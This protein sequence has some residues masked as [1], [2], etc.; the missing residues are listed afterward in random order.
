M[1]IKSKFFLCCFSCLSLLFT[2]N[3][4][5]LNSNNSSKS[6]GD[7]GS[8]STFVDDEFYI[9]DV[10][11]LTDPIKTS[12]AVGE[13]VDLTGMTFQVTW[14]DGY[15]ENVDHTYAI[16][17]PA[18]VK[19]DTTKIIVHYDKFQ[20]ELPVSAVQIA[21]IKIT[22]QPARTVYV[23]NEY[24]NPSGLG[25]SSYLSNGDVYKEILDFDYY[26][27][28]PLTKDDTKITITSSDNYEVELPIQVCDGYVSEAED[29]TITGSGEIAT[30]GSVVQYASG[31]KFVRNFLDGDTLTFK[32]PTTKAYKVDI[33]FVGSSA[34]VEKY[35][36]YENKNFLPLKT[37][38]M[39]AN[40]LFSLAVNGEN[41]DIGDDVIFHGNESENGTYQLFAN[42]ENVKVGE[43]VIGKGTSKVTFTFKTSPYT[44]EDGTYASAFYDKFICIF[45]EETTAPDVPED[46]D[47]ISG[48]KKLEIEDMEIS[49]AVRAGDQSV[50]PNYSS[51]GL[52]SKFS[53]KAFVKSFNIDA[54][55]SYKFKLESYSSL[56]LSLV[57]TPVDNITSEIVFN[58]IFSLYLNEQEITLS[59]DVKFTVNTE[60][61]TLQTVNLPTANCES[62]VNEIKIVFNKISSTYE[63]I[64]LDY[65]NIEVLASIASSTTIDIEA[66]N[67]NVTDAVKAGDGY[68]HSGVASNFSNN[69]FV[70]SFKVGATLSYKFLLGKAANIV[71]SLIGCPTSTTSEVVAKDLFSLYVGDNKVTIGDNVKFNVNS[72]AWSS[73]TMTFTGVDLNPG[74]IEI[75]F[76]FDVITSI[77]EGAFLDKISILVTTD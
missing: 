31:N 55:L 49:D 9:S 67:M 62:G 4:C 47:T 10:K 2:V 71:V 45:K 68:S 64:F 50:H 20:F 77:Y 56:K 3:A 60:A 54:T 53:N 35:V 48:T 57:G 15:V 29:G 43:A 75:K 65:I 7:S 61:Y 36:D 16:A 33:V 69:A 14:N 8:Q 1:K 28:T 5:S 34:C 46:V 30:N 27:K 44:N 25:I 59:D 32:V 6:N 41:I 58:Q 38:D 70:K 21:G 76:V 24:F 66:E 13:S 74:E 17:D 12:F 18:I 23:E 19:S 52:G 51:T 22:K 40:D 63:S 73:Q 26:P 72:V 39:K 11:K 42:W 37:V